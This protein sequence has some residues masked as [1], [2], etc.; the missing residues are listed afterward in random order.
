MLSAGLFLFFKRPSAFWYSVFC[1]SAFGR[2]AVTEEKDLLTFLPDLPWETTLA[3]E[4]LSLITLVFCLVM[5]IKSTFPGM[6]NKYGLIV[7]G[8]CCAAYYV[9]VLLTP[10]LVYTN[11][12]NATVW[13]SRIFLIYVE[14]A[15][16]HDLVRKKQQFSWEH[17]LLFAETIALIS[18]ILLDA[19]WYKRGGYR[20]TLSLTSIGLIVFAFLNM[21]VLVLNFSRTSNE[22]D[23]ARMAEKEMLEI[24]LLTEKLNRVREDFLQNISHEMR[25]PL[26]RMSNCASLTALQIRQNALNSR[27]LENLEVVKR[28]S[29]RLA[30]MVEH[31]KEISVEKERQLSLTETNVKALLVRAADFCEPICQNNSLA[32]DTEEEDM[33]LH[34]NENGIF[35]VLINLIINANRHTKQD[36]ILLKAEWIPDKTQTN[37]VRIRV[38]DHGDGIPPELLTRVFERH[39]SGDGGTGL[40]LPICKE[41]IEEH[42]GTMEI[43]SEQDKGTEIRLIL[44][45]KKG[46]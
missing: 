16:I 34:M 3:L 41:I 40:G 31:L 37:G 29:A 7:Y 23:K 5:Y 36:I 13:I 17:L 27:T 22:R 43:H 44:P 9:V 19:Y 46:K 20:V 45:C 6:L 42:G 14:A 25:T 8:L 39:V 15:L 21:I 32:V 33:I 26:A 2:I 10:P 35:Q 30:E 4:Y 12:L 18:F 11:L 1:L 38:I 28:E 24:N